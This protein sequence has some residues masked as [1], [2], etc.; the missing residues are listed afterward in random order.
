L[1]PQIITQS[2]GTV[3]LS[4]LNSHPT[5]NVN[6]K[7]AQITWPAQPS[8]EVKGFGWNGSLYEILHD[9]D[10]H[11]FDDAADDHIVLNA[12]ATESWEADFDRGSDPS[13]YV[14]GLITVQL[15]FDTPVGICT[16]SRSLNSPPPTATPPP[17]PTPTPVPSPT[18]TA[19][20]VPTTPS[21]ATPT[22][23]STLNWGS[24]PDG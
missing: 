8:L 19:T 18:A 21:G 4:V 9:S 17:P 15:R 23:T 10:G 12:G 16:I 22:P 2:N 24:T 3:S 5:I 13:P 11:A 14:S 1:V 20:P 6:L 7:D